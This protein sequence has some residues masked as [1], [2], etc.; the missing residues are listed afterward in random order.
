[1]ESAV[2]EF[3]SAGKEVFGSLDPGLFRDAFVISL[4]VHDDDDVIEVIGSETLGSDTF[5]GAAAEIQHRL[6]SA[7]RI[8]HE[9]GSEEPLALPLSTAFEHRIGIPITVCE[10]YLT[11]SDTD[12]VPLISGPRRYKDSFWMVAVRLDRAALARQPEAQDPDGDGTLSLVTSLVEEFHRRCL[13]VL[14]GAPRPGP[15]RAV[16]GELLRSAGQALVDE[17]LRPADGSRA[18]MS[19][20][21]YCDA[22]SAMPYEGTESSGR[23]IF[24]REQGRAGT[25][26]VLTLTLQNPVPLHESRTVRKLLELTSDGHA[27]V[28]REG[29]IVGL[30]SLTAQDRDL[31]EARFIGRHIWEVWDAGVAIMRITAGIPGLPRRT[32]QEHTFRDAWTRAISSNE[33]DAALIWSL[34]VGATELGYGTTLVISEDAASESR[35][36]GSQGIPVQPVDAG[37]KLLKSVT[38]VDGA[39]ILDPLGRCHGF[40]MI[41][42]GLVVAGGTRGRGSR[43]NSAVRYATSRPGGCLV[44]VVSDD[45]MVDL[46]TG[47]DAHFE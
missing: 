9:D 7:G 33:G 1:L 45:G 43:F 12:A 13:D 27:M 24:D 16:P 30:S 22:V 26:I 36:L 47:N 15:L 23:M 39:V 40:G 32:L 6:Q 37:Q 34:I 19:I 11:R 41:L 28:V 14:R 10:E 4:S 38:S 42:D 35:R 21:Q 5:V 29:L 44:V 2:G 18:S 17:M 46:I 20:F 3:Q 8:E 25:S 31:T